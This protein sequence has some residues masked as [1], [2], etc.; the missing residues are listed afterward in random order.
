MSLKCEHYKERILSKCADF[1][2]ILSKS[3]MSFRIPLESAN[4]QVAQS[5][6]KYDRGGLWRDV[7]GKDIRHLKCKIFKR[8]VGQFVGLSVIQCYRQQKVESQ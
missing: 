6:V 2:T 8:L 5:N 7:K 1:K 4:F 3:K